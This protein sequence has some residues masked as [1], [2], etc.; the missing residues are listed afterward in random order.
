MAITLL[1]S[2]GIS[3]GV[4]LDSALESEIRELDRILAALADLRTAGAESEGKGD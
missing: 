2:D 1:F 3:V 4:I